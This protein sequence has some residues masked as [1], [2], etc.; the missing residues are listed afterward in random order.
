MLILLHFSL[1]ISGGAV[2]IKKLSN[3]RKEIMMMPI[4]SCIHSITSFILPC[5][6][7]TWV[8]IGDV[9]RYHVKESN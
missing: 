1:S 8:R 7:M 3:K 4:F 6:C 2:S 5:I 9:G